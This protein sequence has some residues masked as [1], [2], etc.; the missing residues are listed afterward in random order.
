MNPVMFRQMFEG[1]VLDGCK[2]GSVDVY[3]VSLLVCLG[4]EDFSA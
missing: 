4:E 3:K 2:D 1:G